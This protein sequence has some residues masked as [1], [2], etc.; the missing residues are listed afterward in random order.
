MENNLDQTINT[1]NLQFSNLFELV[2]EN[3]KELLVLREQG[4]STENN[5]YKI[6]VENQVLESKLVS[7]KAEREMRLSQ[8]AE[9]KLH[10]LRADTADAKQR[11]KALS[12]ACTLAI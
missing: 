4:N 2:Q 11:A 9:H 3:S 5:I 10:M 1:Y 6:S 8:D 7:L 12:D